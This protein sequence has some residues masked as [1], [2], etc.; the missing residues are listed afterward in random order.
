MSKVHEP[1]SFNTSISHV[2][3]LLRNEHCKVTC[4]YGFDVRRRSS[5]FSFPKSSTLY[6]CAYPS[7]SMNE[8]PYILYVTTLKYNYTS[9]HLPHKPRQQINIRFCSYGRN[10]FS[11]CPLRRWVSTYVEIW[12]FRER[13]TKMFFSSFQP[14]SHQCSLFARI[15]RCYIFYDFLGVFKW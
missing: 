10:V 3:H 2:A 11:Y 4:Y 6:V 14:R 12:W 5:C 9:L 15:Y 1:H 7:F 13:K 8:I